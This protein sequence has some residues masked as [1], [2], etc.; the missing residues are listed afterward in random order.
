MVLNA[1][2]Q[3]RLFCTSKDFGQIFLSIAGVKEVGIT[4]HFVDPVSSL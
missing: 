2:Q 4:V 3:S 1:K